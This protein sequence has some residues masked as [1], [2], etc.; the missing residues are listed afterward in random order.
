MYPYKTRHLGALSWHKGSGERISERTLLKQSSLWKR[1]CRKQVRKEAFLRKD[2]PW[3]SSH[4]VGLQIITIYSSTLRG[5]ARLTPRRWS[6][7]FCQ[8][9]RKGAQ[10]TGTGRGWIINFT[11]GILSIPRVSTLAPCSRANAAAIR[12]EA[13]MINWGHCMC[14]GPQG[15]RSLFPFPF[16]SHFLHRYIYTFLFTPHHH[17]YPC[18]ALTCKNKYPGILTY[19][20]TGTTQKAAIRNGLLYTLHLKQRQEFLWPFSVPR[21]EWFAA[22]ILILCIWKNLFKYYLT[23]PKNYLASS[24]LI[25][26]VCPLPWAPGCGKKR[27]LDSCP[28]VHDNSPALPGRLICLHHGPSAKK[29]QLGFLQPIL[30]AQEKSSDNFVFRG[31]PCTE[32]YLILAML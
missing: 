7:A 21:S 12:A 19:A 27:N 4:I 1:V 5:R 17:I 3:E 30:R 6:G 9:Q 22:P 28:W 14:S 26:I 2:V 24:E 29:P 8:P 23:V 15:H 25:F 13:S 31:P 16:S 32:S 18:K 20:G 10:S 11:K